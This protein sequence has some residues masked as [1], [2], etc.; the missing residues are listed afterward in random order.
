[1]EKIKYYGSTVGAV[2]PKQRV[3]VKYSVI[4]FTTN[5]LTEVI[6]TVK[7]MKFGYLKMITQSLEDICTPELCFLMFVKIMETFC[8]FLPL[9]D[10]FH[11]PIDLRLQRQHYI[12]DFIPSWD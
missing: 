3:L 4:E 2:Q 6:Q 1:M 7:I 8:G 11:H 10:I 12:C 9:C 5:I